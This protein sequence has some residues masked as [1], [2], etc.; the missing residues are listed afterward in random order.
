MNSKEAF[1]KWKED[2]ALDYEP[3]MVLSRRQDC[4]AAWNAALAWAK[5][6]QEPVA[7][8]GPFGITSTADF[9]K[10]AQE[11][12]VAL[13]PLYLH[14]APLPVIPEGWKLVPIEPTNDMLKACWPSRYCGDADNYKDMCTY[15][16]SKV[17]PYET[18]WKTEC[19]N[20]FSVKA[21]IEVGWGFA[22]LPTYKYCP[23][24]GKAVIIQHEYK[25]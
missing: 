16:K 23:F 4:E 15:T 12:E 7:W 14:A 20:T 22:P 6:G 10:V 19:G 18:H 13:E 17:T 11:A 9:A 5:E 21:P 1:K 8:R 3:L 2:Y 24:C 25:P